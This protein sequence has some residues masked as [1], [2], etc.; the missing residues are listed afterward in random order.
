MI[1]VQQ[2][3]LTATRSCVREEKHSSEQGNKQSCNMFEEEKN[4]NN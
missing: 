4:I 1:S 3:K 2:N